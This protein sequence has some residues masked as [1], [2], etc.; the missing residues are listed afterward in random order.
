MDERQC[1][2]DYH[3]NEWH[4]SRRN[5]STF[6]DFVDGHGIGG[7]GFGDGVFG[8]IPVC[9]M[10]MLLRLTPFQ[11]YFVLFDF[12]RALPYVICESPLWGFENQ[13]I[14]CKGIINQNKR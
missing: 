11:G 12:H 13:L 9:L 7:I 3:Q 1:F 10:I 8:G 6:F 5:D 4:G 14:V 2:L